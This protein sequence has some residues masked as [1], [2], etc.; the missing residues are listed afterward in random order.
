MSKRSEIIDGRDAANSLYGLVY[1]EVLGW[2]DL[3]QLVP[4]RMTLSNPFSFPT[5]KNS[6]I[7]NRSKDN[8][9][10]LCVQSDLMTIFAL[11]ML[12]LQHVMEASSIKHREAL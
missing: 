8:C 10:I 1:T 4:S 3:G 12:P 6:L 5:R 11:E 9:L 7:Q 2:I